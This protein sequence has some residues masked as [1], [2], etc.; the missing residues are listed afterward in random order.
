MPPTKQPMLPAPAMP[1]GLFE[2]MPPFPSVSSGS[3]TEL[4]A[5]AHREAGYAAL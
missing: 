1:I 5:D 2:I 4:P 3:I